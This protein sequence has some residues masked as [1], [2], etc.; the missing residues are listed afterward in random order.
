MSKIPERIRQEEVVFEQGRCGTCV[1]VRE[2]NSIYYDCA[3]LTVMIGQVKECFAWDDNPEWEGV[4][5]N[6][7]CG[8]AGSMA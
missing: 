1:K 7:P 6:L 5:G 8:K 3:V 4:T 2:V